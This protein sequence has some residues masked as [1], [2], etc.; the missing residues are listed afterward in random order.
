MDMEDE[1]AITTIGVGED[2]I[3]ARVTIEVVGMVEVDKVWGREGLEVVIVTVLDLEVDIV[4]VG[5][6]MDRT[7]MVDREVMEGNEDLEEDMTAT[8]G[9]EGGVE[10]VEIEWHKGVVGMQQL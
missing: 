3:R 1:V 7:D 10:W 4:E 5:E 2:S 8:R 6:V 9:K